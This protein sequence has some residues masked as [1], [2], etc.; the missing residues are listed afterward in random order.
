MINELHA[1]WLPVFDDDPPKPDPP[2]PDPPKP[3]PPKPDPK[4]ATLEK[5]NATL[6]T[7]VTKAI[8]EFKALQTRATVTDDERNEQDARIIELENVVKTKEQLAADKE[9]DLTKGH[10]K[11]LTGMT[12]NRDFWKNLFHVK[13]KHRRIT[14]AAGIEDA[15]NSEQIIALLDPIS[16]LKPKVDSDSKKEIVGE[17]DDEV[18]LPSTN[19]KGEATVLTLTIPLAVKELK[20]QKTSKNLFKGKG[21]GG[22][23]GMQEGDG[24]ETTLEELAGDPKA[25]RAARKKDGDAV[26][27]TTK[28]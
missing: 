8:E 11:E 28:S 17:F 25:Y 23:G 6:K 21:F 3:D 22:L 20:K 10:K 5:E 27:E 19:D 26:L 24:K 12:E 9:R 18:K 14:A 2:K 1:Y 15:F 7:T 4:I 13:E 16:R